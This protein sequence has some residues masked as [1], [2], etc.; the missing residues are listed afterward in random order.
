MLSII[1][2]YFDQE[3]F[4]TSMMKEQYHTLNTS[5]TVR[6]KRNNINIKAGYK[7]HNDGYIHIIGQKMNGQKKRKENGIT[8]GFASSIS[9]SAL[10]S[11]PTGRGQHPQQRQQ[12]RQQQHTA[13]TSLQRTSERQ[14][15]KGENICRGEIQSK[16]ATTPTATKRTT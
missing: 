8:R 6:K 10:T 2:D 9:A 5:W 4:G 3:S 14:Q 7:M 16:D 11:S 13:T 12:R 15:K 1:L